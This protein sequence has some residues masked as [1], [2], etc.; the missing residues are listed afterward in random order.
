LFVIC[1]EALWPHPGVD[2]VVVLSNTVVFIGR[3]TQLIAP[4]NAISSN[5]ITMSALLLC[6][7]LCFTLPCLA[8][9]DQHECPHDVYPT[10]LDGP[11]FLG[12]DKQVLLHGRYRFN[13]SQTRHETSFTIA[14]DSVV[15]VS[16]FSDT[17]D[18]T[19]WIYVGDAH[20]AQV[21]SPGGVGV[22]QVVRG[23]FRCEAFLC[24]C[25]SQ[26]CNV[27]SS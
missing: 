17:L 2:V 10:S 4:T 25:K 5:V 8:L 12:F 21:L 3:G 6:L 11:A 16:A 24:V 27:F 15:R 26:S 13:F 19:I 22:E 7:V 20:T 9:V 18:A 23:T 1:P 14:E